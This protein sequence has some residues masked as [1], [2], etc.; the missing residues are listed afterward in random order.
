M[1]IRSLY[2][3]L[4]AMHNYSYVKFMWRHLDAQQ[5]FKGMRVNAANGR[6]MDKVGFLWWRLRAM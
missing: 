5:P 1:I 3:R 4:Y 6:V 2:G